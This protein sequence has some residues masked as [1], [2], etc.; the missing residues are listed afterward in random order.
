M[1][2]GVFADELQDDTFST[3]ILLSFFTPSLKKE[4]KEERTIHT[5]IILFFGGLTTF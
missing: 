2:V 3:A 5:R 4:S 1:I